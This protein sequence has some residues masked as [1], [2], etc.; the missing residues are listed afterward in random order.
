MSAYAKAIV[1]ALVGALASI[2]S[3]VQA[4][5]TDGEITSE[6]WQLIIT[7]VIGAVVAVVGVYATRNK[8]P[9]VPPV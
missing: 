3:V 1:A 4:A 2:A 7:T 8:P 6:E 9:A 5:I